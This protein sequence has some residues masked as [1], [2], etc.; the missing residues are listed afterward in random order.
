MRQYFS[1]SYIEREVKKNNSIIYRSLI[2]NGYSN[3][4]LEI[5]EYCDPEM[6]VEREQY[7]I[8]TLKP[9]Y[10][11]LTT[12]G[13]LKGFK[14]SEATKKLI[15][16]TNKNCIVSEETRLKIAETLSKGVKIIVRDNE[17]GKIQSFVSIRQAAIFLGIQPSYVAKQLRENSFYLGK[18]F[19]VY[20]SNTTLEEVLKSEG[21]LSAI[22]K[23]ELSKHTEISRE[24][25]RKSLLGKKLSLEVKEKLSLNSKNAKQVLVVNNETLET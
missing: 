4:K 24:L 16:E 20:S 10:N 9:E 18:G 14:H 11:I 13:S 17:D 5:L 22:A 12:A 25:I 1:I 19:L 7:Y 21:Y 3:F 6:V 8:D 2:K 15:S 23:G